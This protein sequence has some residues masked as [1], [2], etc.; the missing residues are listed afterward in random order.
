MHNRPIG[1]FDSGLGGLSALRVLR[2]LLPNEDL[3]YFGDTARVPYGNR[4]AAII[5]Q[6]AKSD[7]AVLRHYDVKYILIA[8]GTVSSVLDVDKLGSDVP[9]CGVIDPT[10]EAAKKATKNGRIG[11]IATAATINSGSYHRALDGAQVFTA[12]CPL[13]VPLVE[14]G[15]VGENDE[16]TLTAARQ[17]LTP[18]KEKGVDTLILG[19]T[20]YPLI[21]PIIKK[22]MG[23]GVTLIDSGAEA[24]KYT[25][26]YLKNEGMLS[27][28][29]GDTT[30]LISDLPQQFPELARQFMGY[31]IEATTID[32]DDY[33]HEEMI[34]N[35]RR[36]SY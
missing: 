20:H 36:L 3:V 25:A 19:C 13:F 16:L 11:V 4:S 1:V 28:N 17:Y 14:H 9:I 31:D 8:C 24:A 10:A 12:A 15:H 5:E 34:H 32:P 7:I 6:F 26:D 27:S 2:E 21:A 23:E 29:G 30:Y 18:L 22:V 35:E 33:I